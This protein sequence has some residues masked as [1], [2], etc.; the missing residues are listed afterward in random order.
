MRIV[1]GA[2]GGRLC[3]GIESLGALVTGFSEALAVMQ[4]CLVTA[5]SMDVVPVHKGLDLD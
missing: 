5:H 3:G 1:D 2:L 4:R